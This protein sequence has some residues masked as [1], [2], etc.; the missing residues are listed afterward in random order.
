MR[1]PGRGLAGYLA[2][3]PIEGGETLGWTED[4]GVLNGVSGVALA[5]LGAITT[6][7]PAWDRMLLMSLSPRT[8]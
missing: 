5:L 6:N 8:A 1:T 3:G 2:H 4:P 7:E